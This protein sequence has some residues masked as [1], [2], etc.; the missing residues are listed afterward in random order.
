MKRF[1]G[2][3]RT[4]MRSLIG[5]PAT[6]MYPKR[7]RIYASAT[8]GRVENEIEECIFCRL[9]EKNCP[10]GALS[11]SK[12]KKEWQI[13][14]LRCCLCRRCVE[15]CPK[16]CLTMHDAYFAPVRSRAEGVYLTVLPPGP[17]EPA[18]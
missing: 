16:D 4:I 8:R 1:P 18:K 5:K 11:A 10:T 14:S 3:S 7:K 15:I 17:D 9:C 12:E 6:L 2:I 13:D